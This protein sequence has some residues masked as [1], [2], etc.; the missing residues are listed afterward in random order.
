ME[1]ADANIDFIQEQVKNG[2]VGCIKS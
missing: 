2:S 1:K